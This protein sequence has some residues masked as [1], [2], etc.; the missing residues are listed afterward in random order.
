MSSE[1]LFALGPPGHDGSAC[2]LAGASFERRLDL[3]AL[4]TNGL[5]IDGVS[6]VLVAVR[7]VHSVKFSTF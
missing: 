1:G 4:A 7:A 2:L 5:N 3:A 6:N